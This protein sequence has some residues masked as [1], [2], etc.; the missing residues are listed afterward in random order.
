MQATIDDLGSN[1]NDEGIG[2]GTGTRGKSS[3]FGWAMF[4]QRA[5]CNAPMELTEPP[6]GSMGA[7]DGDEE[8]ETGTE[9]GTARTPP[10]PP[11]PGP[12]RLAGRIGGGG[13]ENSN[14]RCD[15]HGLCLHRQSL[16]CAARR[17]PAC[18][19]PLCSGMQRHAAALRTG[20]SSRARRGLGLE[21]RET[22]PRQ[23]ECPT[24]E[25][26]LSRPP[27]LPPT[28]AMRAC[29]C[30]GCVPAC[31][32]LCVTRHETR[33]TEAPPRFTRVHRHAGSTLGICSGS[34]PGRQK[35]RTWRL[36]GLDKRWAD[37]G[38]WPCPPQLAQRRP[39]S[40]VATSDEIPLSPFCPGLS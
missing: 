29:G 9:T 13:R 32:V 10:L 4:M 19:M 21:L 11:P 27:G 1:P 17:A 14:G 6:R 7:S 26:L 38:P 30:I 2:R 24:Q 22:P 5:R 40:R 8:A 33:V 34:L 3:F 36:V 18:P 15:L 23:R 12:L 31:I 35:A 25:A 28:K 20:R 16:F 37:V 39:P